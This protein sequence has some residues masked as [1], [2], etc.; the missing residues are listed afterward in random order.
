MVQTFDIDT[1]LFRILKAS[2]ELASAITGEIL[3]GERPVG[4][5]VEDVT[6]NTPSLT[7]EHVPQRGYTNINLHVP[8]ITVKV[9]GQEQKHA[10]RSRMRILANQVVEI[11]R[12]ARVPGL[13]FVIV[14]QSVVPEPEISQHYINIRI[15]WSI[16]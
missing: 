10:D 8:D 14:G 3:T 9:E 7:Q 15:D 1:E 6:I 13:G 4:S 5:M 11:I 12:S 2:S 16:H